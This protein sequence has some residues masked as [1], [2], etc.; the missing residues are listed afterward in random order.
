MKKDIIKV[1]VT[2]PVNESHKAKLESVSDLA[3]IRCVPSNELTEEAVSGAE[4]ILGNIPHAL[5]PA[6]KSLKLLQLGS[7]GADGYPELMPEGARLTNSSGAYGL[8]ISE[9][10]LGMLLA[11]KKKLYLYDENQR[12]A[13]WQDEGPVTSIEGAYVLSVGMGDIGG[14]FAKKCKA[15]GAYTVGVRRSTANKPEYV[16][17]LHTLDSIDALLPKADVVALSL[18]SGAATNGLMNEARLRLLKPGAVLI[19]VGRGSAIVTEA[20]VKV[21]SEGRIFA[22]LDVTDPEPLPPEHP[23]WRLP[24]VHITPHISGFFH[25]PQTLERIVAISAENL[26]RYASGEPLLNLVDPGTSYRR[27]EN[28]ADENVTKQ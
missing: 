12:S 18:P 17:E 24:N 28:R 5:L 13:L 2:L 10:M 26:R 16:D 23:L 1:L 3:E 25:L 4:V 11:V 21:C 7:A 8:A 20:L 6:C 9:H 27:P 15:L 19:N 14:E 22:A